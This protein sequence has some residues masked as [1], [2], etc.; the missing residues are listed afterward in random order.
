MYCFVYKA[1]DAK[2]CFVFSVIQVYVCIRSQPHLL[3][4]TDKNSIEVMEENKVISDTANY[5]LAKP[6]V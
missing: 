4:D 3:E 6:H 5:Y 1:C 2:N